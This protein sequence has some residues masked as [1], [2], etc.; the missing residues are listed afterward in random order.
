MRKNLR[1]TSS[2]APHGFWGSVRRLRFESEPIVAQS[3]YH[4]R[5]AERERVD[6]GVAFDQ[7]GH[8][9]AQYV[10]LDEVFSVGLNLE[11]TLEFRARRA[12]GIIMAVGSRSEHSDHMVLQLVNGS[13]LVTVDNGAGAITAQSPTP[14]PDYYCDGQWHSLTAVKERNIISLQVDSSDELVGF[15]VGSAANLKSDTNMP[16]FIGAIPEG[17]IGLVDVVA[18]RT[19]FDGCIRN[20]KIDSKPIDFTSAFGS[21]EFVSG[22][23]PL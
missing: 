6:T 12:N 4:A 8:G 17:S 11:I 23:C 5:S 9:A 22:F 21:T 13:L 18:E 19:P 7:L 14:R 2:E 10:V 16:L 3:W 20:V 15:D 1:L